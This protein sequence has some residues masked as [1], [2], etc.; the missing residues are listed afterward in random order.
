MKHYTHIMT[1]KS[2]SSSM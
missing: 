2:N 1:T